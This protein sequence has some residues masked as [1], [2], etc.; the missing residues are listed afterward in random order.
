MFQCNGNTKKLNF[1]LIR[2]Y[3]QKE[4]NINTKPSKP[5][6]NTQNKHLKC[7]VT[8]ISSLAF[9]YGGTSKDY[10]GKMNE[11]KSH[12]NKQ[13]NEEKCV[14]SA[15][16][17]NEKSDKHAQV[18]K[19]ITGEDEKLHMKER[20]MSISNNEKT[21][22][23]C[24][25]QSSHISNI[26]QQNDHHDVFQ[27]SYNGAYGEKNN[28]KNINNYGIENEFLKRFEGN[29]KNDNEIKNNQ[30][31]H[32]ENKINFSEK[33]SS[34]FEPHN[35]GGHEEKVYNKRIPKNLIISNEISSASSYPLHMSALSFSKQTAMTNSNMTRHFNTIPNSSSRTDVGETAVQY[36]TAC[37]ESTQQNKT[38][39]T[40]EFM[41]FINKALKIEE[42]SNKKYHNIGKQGEEG[43]K[44]CCDDVESLNNN[45]H[46]KTRKNCQLQTNLMRAVNNAL[47]KDTSKSNSGDHFINDNNE[48]TL[49]AKKLNINIFEEII[50]NFEKIDFDEF[51]NE[52]LKC[53]KRSNNDPKNTANLSNGDDLNSYKV[54]TNGIENIPQTN[55]LSYESLKYFEGNNAFCN[56]NLKNYIIQPKDDK[57]EVCITDQANNAETNEKLFHNFD[58]N[59]KTAVSRKN[60]M[61]DMKAGETSNNDFNRTP[62]SFCVSLEDKINKAI[63]DFEYTN[64]NKSQNRMS[65][66]YEQHLFSD[67]KTFQKKMSENIFE[68]S[69]SN[70]EIIRTRS[71]GN[72]FLEAK[73]FKKFE[74]GSEDKILKETLNKKRNLRMQ[75]NS[76]KYIF[77]EENFYSFDNFE[78]DDE[79]KGSIRIETKGIEGNKMTSKKEKINANIPKN[80]TSPPLNY[81]LQSNGCVKNLEHATASKKFNLSNSHVERAKICKL[82]DFCGELK[83]L[84]HSQSFFDSAFSLVKDSKNSRKEKSH[85][86]EGREFH[87]TK[88]NGDFL[89]KNEIKKNSVAYYCSLE[90][91][92]N[93]EQFINPKKLN[94]NLCSKDI[95]QKSS[96]TNKI[97]RSINN[98]G[99]QQIEKEVNDNKFEY[100]KKISSLYKTKA[101]DSNGSI[102][103]QPKC[104]V[105]SYYYDNRSHQNMNSQTIEGNHIDECYKNCGNIYRNIKRNYSPNCQVNNDSISKDLNENKMSCIGSKNYKLGEVLFSHLP[106]EASQNG[107]P[108]VYN[109]PPNESE[110]QNIFGNSNLKEGVEK[111]QDVKSTRDQQ[112]LEEFNSSNAKNEEITEKTL[113]VMNKIT[114]T[115]ISLKNK[116]KL[117]DDYSLEKNNDASTLQ[118]PSRLPCGPQ[119]RQNHSLTAASFIQ[120][121]TDLE[122][123]PPVEDFHFRSNSILPFKNSKPPPTPDKL[124]HLQTSEKKSLEAIRQRLRPKKPHTNCFSLD[125]LDDISED[126]SSST[127]YGSSASGSRKT[128]KDKKIF[129]KIS[130]SDKNNI[131]KSEKD[132]YRKNK[133][134]G[135][136]KACRKCGKKCSDGC[137]DAYNSMLEMTLCDEADHS[138]GEQLEEDHGFPNKS[139][140]IYSKKYKYRIRSLYG[141]SIDTSIGNVGFDKN[142]FHTERSESNRSMEGFLP[143]NFLSRSLSNDKC[144]ENKNDD[145][146]FHESYILNC[147]KTSSK[148]QRR[149][150]IY[151][152]SNYK[153]GI[154]IRMR[155]P[156]TKHLNLSTESLSKTQSPIQHIFSHKP[157]TTTQ[158]STVQLRQK[159]S[160]TERRSLSYTEA[161]PGM[162][163][164]SLVNIP[165][166][167]MARLNNDGTPKSILK[168]KNS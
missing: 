71:C 159:T 113:E 90:D 167:A 164:E 41:H 93:Y 27:S 23:I 43:G 83:A 119:E 82:S 29:T 154:N 128:Y 96:L 21:C 85:E 134:T 108:Q 4:A 9:T 7:D 76:L 166:F 65:D 67:E 124:K 62:R 160:K 150:Y 153:P 16:N 97:D 137:E 10:P 142:D 141:N 50:E 99:K 162:P 64:K 60:A 95:H 61:K 55:E 12:L 136:K 36:N 32:G 132:A 59:E 101:E 51:L 39:Q 139:S 79:C 5:N 63:Y 57:E 114:P 22:A 117:K 145:E 91:L 74:N 161:P 20:L 103:G 53:N 127:G 81:N 14:F 118:S 98:R 35:T 133:L 143:R 8:N 168:N 84:N 122:I 107:E 138:W 152:K 15:G 131:E 48:S 1:D 126:E 146:N 69:K 155:R 77:Q 49:R 58:F 94:I 89:K 44:H 78:N 102:T 19:D 115:F 30:I 105:D 24:T 18:N 6:V 17:I 26:P 112:V 72:E 125:N 47:E 106:M 100:I 109:K 163:R 11:K 116:K 92:D 28:S 42:V 147:N 3:E 120:D 88:S 34:S 121:K 68:E 45:H 33:Y 148:T 151:G 73:N 66:N 86:I 56:L 158:S 140:Q 75:K 110:K 111:K 80:T 52:K 31:T 157:V 135:R 13:P 130:N 156:S 54:P 2:A 87:E 165:R 149:H 38:N 129:E 123:K 37:G 144:F 40:E 70:D 46:N 104:S 25:C